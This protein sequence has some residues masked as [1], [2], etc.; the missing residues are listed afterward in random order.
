MSKIRQLRVVKAR[1]DYGDRELRKTHEDDKKE[2][3]NKNKE[4]LDKLKE[5]I[6]KEY[7]RLR[8]ATDSGKDAIR[9]LIEGLKKRFNTI[10]KQEHGEEYY[11]LASDEGASPAIDVNRGAT[12]SK[13]RK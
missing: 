9:K 1:E 2:A 6:A 7:E 13:N 8:S 11:T 4:L 10:Y 3:K 5:K 12:F